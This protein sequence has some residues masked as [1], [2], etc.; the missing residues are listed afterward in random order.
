MLTVEHYELIRRK[1]FID[2]MSSRAIAHELGHSRK[3]IAKAL[4][5]A[6]PPGYRRAVPAACPVMDKFASIVEAWREQDQQRPAKQRHTAQRIYERLSDEHEFKGSSSTIRRY[7]HKS[8]SC[9]AP[10]FMP[11]AFDPGEEAQVDWHEGWIIERG[12][13]RKAQFFYMR[14][15]YSKASFVRAYERADLISF[16]DGHVKAF[17]YFRG[18]PKR[19]AYDNLKS[20]VTQVKRGRDRELNKKFIELRSCYLFDT[21]FCNVAKGNEKGDVE[22]PRGW[23]SEVRGNT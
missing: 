11:L 2:G 17:E 18:V 1:H 3:T 10:V 5:Q 19:L 13:Q 14:L 4:R 9:Q 7:I 6:V 15:C 22:N 20:A 23:R 16:L 12:V 21:R 8:R